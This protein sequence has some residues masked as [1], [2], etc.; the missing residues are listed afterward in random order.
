MSNRNAVDHSNATRPK[1]RPDFCLW[2]ND[3]L[4]LKAELKQ[5]PSELGAAKDELMSKMRGWCRRAAWPPLSPLLR[6][7]W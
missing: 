5:A 2:M 7:G 3:A 4:V 1:L 6:S